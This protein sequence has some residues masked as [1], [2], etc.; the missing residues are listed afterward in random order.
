MTARS[1]LKRGGPPTVGKFDEV[2]QFPFA[3]KVREV[4][5]ANAPSLFRS[6]NTAKWA[7]IR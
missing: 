2:R 5:L 7:A 6:E 3:N 1:R 4:A